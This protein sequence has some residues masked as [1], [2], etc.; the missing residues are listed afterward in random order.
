[1][2]PCERVYG[3]LN[4]TRSRNSD[5][6][7]IPNRML[8]RRLPARPATVAPLHRV[9]ATATLLAP[10]NVNKPL[11][12]KLV[13]IDITEKSKDLQPDRTRC[14]IVPK[15]LE[16]SR[17]GLEALQA[18]QPPRDEDEAPLDSGPY[19]SY[20]SVPI[21]NGRAFRQRCESKSR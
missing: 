12:E 20:S 7:I 2:T 18:C 19:R 14:S 9:H 17:S 4:T 11:L 3:K 21:C 13:N 8:P 15:S 5:A 16:I 6:F 1:M 10:V